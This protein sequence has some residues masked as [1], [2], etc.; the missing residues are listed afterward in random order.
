M[1]KARLLAELKD[2]YNKINMFEP[3]IEFEASDKRIIYYI[4]FDDKSL[5]PLSKK[6]IYINLS[7]KCVSKFNILHEFDQFLCDEL[8]FF[9]R[10]GFEICNECSERTGQ[11][12]EDWWGNCKGPNKSTKEKLID[13]LLSLNEEQDAFSLKY[14]NESSMLYIS[15]GEIESELAQMKKETLA[16]LLNEILREK[17]LGAPDVYN[18]TGDSASTI[19]RILN[20]VTTNPSTIT[21]LKIAVALQCNLETTTKLLYAAG[22]S[23]IRDVELVLKVYIMRGKYD[24]ME[25]DDNLRKMRLGTVFSPE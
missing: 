17:G 22:R 8:E 6:M 21:V 2:L 11:I 20:G 14:D 13:E 19:N 10:S 3:R 1:E 7:N 18:K 23:A 15:I 24:L 4:Y 9:D 25:I 5:S 16:K 12:I